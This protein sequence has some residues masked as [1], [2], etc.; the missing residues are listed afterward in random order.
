[1]AFKL[2]IGEFVAGVGKTAS[3]IIGNTVDSVVKAVDQ[4]DDG[5]LDLKDV[6]VVAD[7]IGNAAMNTVNSIKEVIE[8]STREA[9]LRALQPLFLEDL[10]SPDFSI[11][12][13]IRLTDIDKKRAESELCKGSVGFLS[14]QKDLRVVNI[15]RD[16][17][18]AFGLTFFPDKDCEVY[19]VDPSDRDRY[20]ALEDYFS[21]LKMVRINELQKIA[22]DLGAKHFRVTYKEQ[23][24]DSSKKEIKAKVSTKEGKESVNTGIERDMTSSEMSTVEI[25]AEM[26]CPG[27][28]PVEPSLVY[29]QKEPCIHSLIALRMD[30]TSPIYHQ[31]YTIKLSNSS[32]I[33]EKEAMKIDAVLTAMKLSGSKTVTNEAQKESRRFFEYEIDF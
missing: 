10:D 9:E 15:F 22:Q 17:T 24:E 23:K 8:K 20:I 14:E 29:L 5:E 33:K 1:M 27:H 32:G 19:Y 2:N 11:S 26:D 25:A 4:N 7:S 3:N 13:L 31:K 18:D 16:K 21:Y 12:K 28:A 6:A 30:E